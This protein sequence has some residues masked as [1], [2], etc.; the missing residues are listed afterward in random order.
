MGTGVSVAVGV[1][2]ALG[3]RVGVCVGVGSGVGHTSDSRPFFRKRLSTNAMDPI[4][5]PASTR[6]W[7][8][9]ALQDELNDAGRL[10]GG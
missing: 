4:V 3:V 10:D 8:R 7:P 2:D 9:T 6:K 1:A 5:P